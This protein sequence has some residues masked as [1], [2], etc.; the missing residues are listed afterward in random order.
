M[1][2]D[3]ATAEYTNENFNRRERRERKTKTFDTNFT[4]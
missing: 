4:D 2:T 1:D 3:L